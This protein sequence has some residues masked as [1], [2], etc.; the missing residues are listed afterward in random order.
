[1]FIGKPL[2]AMLYGEGADYAQSPSIRT[3]TSLGKNQSNSQR[4]KPKDQKTM[5]FITHKILSKSFRKY[6]CLSKKHNPRQKL[7][8]NTHVLV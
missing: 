1:M 7:S 6:R 8:E 3:L 2:S 4:P 5:T